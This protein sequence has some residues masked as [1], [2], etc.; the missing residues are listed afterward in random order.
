MLR[1]A[2][3]GVYELTKKVDLL[4]AIQPANLPVPPY[5]ASKENQAA[6]A[7]FNAASFE[8]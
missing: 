2:V 7:R 1:C 4:S 6:H 5:K 8:D 3:C